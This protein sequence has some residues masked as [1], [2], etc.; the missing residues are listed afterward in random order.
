MFYMS[1]NY[2]IAQV[3]EWDKEEMVQITL[4]VYFSIVT[5]IKIVDLFR[6]L[7]LKK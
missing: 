4:H 1:S 5:E 2:A 3:T 6:F 7:L